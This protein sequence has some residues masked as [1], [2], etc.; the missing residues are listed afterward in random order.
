[1]L[2]KR[3]FFL[4]FFRH[5][6][7][8][9][10]LFFFPLVWSHKPTQKGLEKLIFQGGNGRR[11]SFFFFPFKEVQ[12]MIYFIRENYSQKTILKTKKQNSQKGFLKCWTC[13]F[14]PPLLEAKQNAHENQQRSGWARLES[15]VAWP[16]GHGWG[17]D[18][19]TQ[20]LLLSKRM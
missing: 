9:F 12:L 1:M 10:L 7:F 17:W 3:F 15:S 14:S 4:S 18:T 13:Q 2:Q 5:V 6:L 8:L 16:Q 19:Y 11:T 20:T